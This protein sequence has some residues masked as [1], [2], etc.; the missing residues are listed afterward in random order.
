MK[1]TSAERQGDVPLRLLKL[2][3]PRRGQ[4]RHHSRDHERRYEHRES[5]GCPY[6]ELLLIRVHRGDHAALLLLRDAYSAFVS[7]TESG[8][9]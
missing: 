3:L 8:F 6:E 4:V 1:A 7:T 2:F 5:H 9:P